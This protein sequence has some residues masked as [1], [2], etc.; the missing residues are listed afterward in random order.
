MS[1]AWRDDAACADCNE[2]ELFDPLGEREP[3]DHMMQ[4]ARIAV[5]RYCAICPVIEPC[6]QEAE[7]HEYLGVWSGCV[8][9]RRHTRDLLAGIVHVS[10]R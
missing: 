8:R 2:P 5:A 1:A 3:A 9:E 6:R 7:V 10:N 4:R